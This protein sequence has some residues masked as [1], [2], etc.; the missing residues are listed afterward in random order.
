MGEVELNYTPMEW[1]L[2]CIWK[3]SRRLKFN[4]ERM[5]AGNSIDTVVV[6]PEEMD[7]KIV[8]EMSQAVESCPCIKNL[9]ISLV[10]DEEE[11][12]NIFAEA[13]TL[14]RKVRS[15]CNVRVFIRMAELANAVKVALRDLVQSVGSLQ[16][17]RVHSFGA[18]AETEIIDCCLE[19]LALRDSI[20]SF[21]FRS[22]SITADKT[23][24]SLT[25][26]LKEASCLHEIEMDLQ[27]ENS[28]T[29]VT[30][31]MSKIGS[32]QFLESLS[33]SVQE[34][35]GSL[36]IAIQD[37]LHLNPA[38]RIFTLKV[39]SFVE[40]ALGMLFGSVV[41]SGLDEFRFRSLMSQQDPKSAAQIFQTAST[42]LFQRTALRR[43]C[44]DTLSP[45]SEL[46]NFQDWGLE[47]VDFRLW[48]QKVSLKCIVAAVL[49]QKSLAQVSMRGLDEDGSFLLF[50]GLRD[51]QTIQDF[52][53]SGSSL[54]DEAMI[55]ISESL[56][57]NRVIISLHFSDCSISTLGFMHLAKGIAKNRSLQ[58]VSLINS[59]SSSKLK[60][61][62]DA[63]CSNSSIV[64]VHFQSDGEGSAIME[65]MM[66][67]FE[68]AIAENQSL[69][70]LSG[71]LS[72]VPIT[73]SNRKLYLQ[74]S[75]MALLLRFKSYIGSNKVEKEIWRTI[76]CY[77]ALWGER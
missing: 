31:V 16:C 9:E 52:R 72:P 71:M 38:L 35:D 63:L 4:V 20:V 5:C 75:R 68:S 56:V 44:L 33:L 53:V 69:V 67:K 2:P 50:E 30:T 58:R 8:D 55:R 18:A 41:H 45:T 59:V 47:I 11:L 70:E 40:R 62:A 54:S 23:A 14:L 24:E 17:L 48:N 1:Q 66:K 49:A 60:L 13:L 12:I 22:D 42:Y 65:P 46:E 61:L 7:R 26:R 57:S 37:F 6:N 29:V 34:L 77:A 28:A 64:S 43:L 19:G 25:G 21:Y 73:V 10:D 36:S 27:A 74:N 32:L 39:Y 51:S 3:G 76:F 15:V